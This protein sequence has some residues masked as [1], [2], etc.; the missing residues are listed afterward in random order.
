MNERDL[1][2]F[3]KLIELGSYTKTAR[4]FEVTQPTIS[5]A[6]KRLAHQYGDP[7]ITQ[8]NR[9]S[10]LVLTTA[11]MILYEKGLNLIN[12]L[13]S[14]NYDVGHAN[15]KKIR[16]AFSGIAGG[17]YMPDIVLAFYQAGIA[18]M[19]DPTFIRSSSAL[20]DLSAG[21]VDVAIYSWN[22]PFNDPKYYLR[23][24]EVT[25]F[26]IICRAD[27][28]L[29]KLD[30][31]AVDQL[32]DFEFIAR[33]REY[34]TTE[35]LLETCH[36][37]DFAPNII[38][39]ANTLELMISLVQRGMGVAFILESRIRDVAGIAVVHIR[40]LQRM[41]SY[42][43]IAMRKSFI[44]NKYQRKG[45]EILRNFKAGESPRE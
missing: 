15:D 9:K 20:K 8:E 43:Q 44:P 19:L 35:A 12:D 21:K 25:D 13:K 22:V 42:S 1:T 39:T 5:A 14:L 26:V 30:N 36:K 38:Y 2:Y 40:P 7:L 16:I 4:F 23:T 11:G 28:P 24:L 6:V 37:E 3:C 10:K 32:R 29:A 27:S 41:Y 33:D 31:I 34:L 18:S 45:I 17:F